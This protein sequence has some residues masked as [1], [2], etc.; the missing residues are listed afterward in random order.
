MTETEWM[1]DTGNIAMDK[2]I[3]MLDSNEFRPD[4]REMIFYFQGKIDSINIY[5]WPDADKTAEARAKLL[6]AVGRVE[7]ARMVKIATNNQ[8]ENSCRK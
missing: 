6:E 4:S 7:D 1:K 2:I 5:L 3:S 8:A